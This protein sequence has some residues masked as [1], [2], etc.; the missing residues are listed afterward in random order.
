MNRGVFL[1]LGLCVLFVLE[2][3]AILETGRN[4]VGVVLNLLELRKN[5]VEIQDMFS[6]LETK[7]SSKIRCE[8][9][10]SLTAQCARSLQNLDTIMKNYLNCV[11]SD[12]CTFP[13][14]E[15]N[16]VLDELSDSIQ[17]MTRISLNIFND[18]VDAETM[19]PTMKP[20]AK[21]VKNEWKAAVVM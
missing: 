8:K 11:L 16:K 3:H 19:K 2:I 13:A 7:C 17:V 10:E 14:G 6:V 12:T 4:S 20:T 18:E 15:M 5:L 9:A 1:W 21:L